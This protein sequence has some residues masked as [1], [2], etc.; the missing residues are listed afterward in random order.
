MNTPG[1]DRLTPRTQNSERWL[2]L[3]G[4]KKF[5]DTPRQRAKDGSSRALQRGGHGH[6]QAEPDLACHPGRWNAWTVCALRAR[7]EWRI[8]PRLS[9]VP[10]SSLAS[11]TKAPVAI[12][13]GPL[14][15]PS[16]VEFI[17]APFCGQV[18]RP[19]P[20]HAERRCRPRFA[21]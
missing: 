19:R 1:D 6:S 5:P 15:T 8:H 2:N 18:A 3:V 16:G 14:I 21:S 4:W 12:R 20:P 13:A 11:S 17:L 9:C 7:E 10:D